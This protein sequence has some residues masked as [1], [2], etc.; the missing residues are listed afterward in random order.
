MDKTKIAA[1]DIPEDI[2]TLLNETPDTAGYAEEIQADLARLEAEP[3]WVADYLKMQFVEDTLAAMERQGI[4][5]SELA[6]RLGKSR[7]YVGRVLNER[8]NFTLD[9]MAQIACALGAHIATRLYRPDERMAILPARSKP[10]PLELI[11]M[12]TC[13]DT[14]QD[15]A[16]GDIDAEYFAA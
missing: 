4:D 8:A 14:P 5:R 13:E 16:S 10:R 15:A 1:P 11:S 7:Q 3:E 12:V 2:Q 6:R 9:S